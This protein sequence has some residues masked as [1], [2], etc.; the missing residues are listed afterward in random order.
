MVN[1]QNTL[2]SK[3]VNKNFVLVENV[4]TVDRG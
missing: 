2:A 4:I 1:Y 3:F